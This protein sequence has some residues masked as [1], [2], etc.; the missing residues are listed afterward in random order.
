[1][2]KRIAKC[3]ENVSIS[4]W[5]GRNSALDKGISNK[6]GVCSLYKY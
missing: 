4:M 6:F 3:K 5:V 2:Y 1:M